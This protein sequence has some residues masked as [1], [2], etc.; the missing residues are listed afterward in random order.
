[1][2]FAAVMAAALASPA[3]ADA[4]GVF[5]RTIARL[6]SYPDPLYIVSTDIWQTRST[7]RGTGEVTLT[8]EPRRF[9]FRTSDAMEYTSSPPADKRLPPAAI[10][11]AFV[12]PT[13]WSLHAARRTGEFSPLQSQMAPDVESLKTI[14]TV[15]AVAPPVYRSE[16]LGM[17]MLDGHRVYH[18]RLTPDRDPVKHNLHELWVDAETFDLRKAKFS[19]TYQPASSAPM[20][21]SDVVATFTGVGAYWLVV[22]QT[23]TYAP[24]TGGASFRFEVTTTRFA[25]PQALPD[26]IFDQGSYDKH[27]RAGE[28]DV[29]DPILE[30]AS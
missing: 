13:A 4:A 12:G 22:D 14:A 17:E 2:I 16:A 6:S 28:A 5:K 3:P 26:W 25:F 27:Q 23:W 15:T 19:G 18:L 21:P 20:A 29:L 8:K 24:V 10:V 11:H 9:A 7:A 1:M 30:G